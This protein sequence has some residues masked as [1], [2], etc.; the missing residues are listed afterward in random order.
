MYV[1][2]DRL[3]VKLEPVRPIDS[4]EDLWLLEADTSFLTKEK[5]KLQLIGEKEENF[6][7]LFGPSAKIESTT[8]LLYDD[9]IWTHTQWIGLL[10]MIIMF[11][12]ATFPVTLCNRQ[13]DGYWRWINKIDSSSHKEKCQKND[14]QAKICDDDLKYW[15]FSIF[16]GFLGITSFKTSTFSEDSTFCVSCRFNFSPCFHLQGRRRVRICFHIWLLPRAGKWSQNAARR[17]LHQ[18]FLQNLRIE[19]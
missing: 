7:F 4:N 12:S 13:L 10:I 8:E 5:H 9:M 11:V 3:K 19:I 15:L 6:E 14:S 1:K 16:C 17:T 2:I 18:P